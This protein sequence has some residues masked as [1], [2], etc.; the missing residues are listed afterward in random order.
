M[1]MMLLEEKDTTTAI[2]PL[3]KNPGGL[4]VGL[5]K[6]GKRGELKQVPSEF[7]GPT[8]LTIGA[9]PDKAT[10]NITLLDLLAKIN[11]RKGA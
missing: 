7:G 1:S 11:K 8:P 10:Q 9:T 2:T 3:R 4:R 6:T 5:A